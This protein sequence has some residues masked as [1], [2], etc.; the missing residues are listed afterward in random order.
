MPVL[1][2]LAI[3]LMMFAFTSTGSSYSSGITESTKERTPLESS[4]VN[5]YQYYYTDELGWFGSGSDIES[6]MKH[7]YKETGVQPYLYLTDTVMGTNLPSD[8]QMQD[9]AENIYNSLFTDDGHLVLL[10]RQDDN[11]YGDYQMW[12]TAGSR[13]KY[14]ID[15]E[16][17]NILMDYIES[18]YY[19]DDLSEEE[20]FGDAF[21]QAAD[22]I[23]NKASKKTSGFSI[24]LILLAVALVI[25]AFVSRSVNK[26]KEKAAKEKA[27]RDEILKTPLK[28]FSS[29]GIDDL[30]EKY[31]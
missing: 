10:F 9:Y 22:R 31:Q 23:M 20:V 4:A 27:E 17:R 15:T 5:E 24:V 29:E 21:S 1:L 12:V 18:C 19:N 3:L 28:K 30:K 2:L 13:A 8:Q 26:A 25:A 7:F 16:A 6:G 11:S 14:V